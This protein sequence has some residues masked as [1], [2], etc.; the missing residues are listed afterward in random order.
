MSADATPAARS[1]K[2]PCSTSGLAADDSAAPEP[3]TDADL[4]PDNCDNCPGEYNPTQVDQDGDQVGDLCDICISDY[5]PGQQD[6]DGDGLGDPCDPMPVPVPTF[7]IWGL[8]VLAV[9][10]VA[11]AIIVIR[12]RAEGE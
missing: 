3:D 11:G 9:I 5:N 12:R 4:F 10:L 7:N 1:S 6:S 8:L 2:T